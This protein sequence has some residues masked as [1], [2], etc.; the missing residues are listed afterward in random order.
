LFIAQ[1]RA[2]HPLISPRNE[3]KQS[4]F[5]DIL[6]VFDMAKVS[7]TRHNH[8]VRKYAESSTDDETQDTVHHDLT[9]LHESEISVSNTPDPIS[10]SLSISTRTMTKTQNTP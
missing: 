4:L 5:L 9:R 10:R 3:W 6:V 7:D 8:H 1:N 2:K